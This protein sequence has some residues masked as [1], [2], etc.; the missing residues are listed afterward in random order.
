M[1]TFAFLPILELSNL[2]S[3]H[4]LSVESTG[5][6]NWTANSE[7][8]TRLVRKWLEGGGGGGGV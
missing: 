4:S 8:F 2:S 5:K 3:L 6:H 7:L 1:G